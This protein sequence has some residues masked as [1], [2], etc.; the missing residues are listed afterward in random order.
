MTK[1][2]WYTN[3]EYIHDTLFATILKIYFNIN[4][5]QTFQ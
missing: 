2:I 1:H 3:D 5:F 4:D